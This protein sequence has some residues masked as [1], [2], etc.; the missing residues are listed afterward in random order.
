MK[1]TH[2]MEM[3]SIH[4]L[5]H[6]PGEEVDFRSLWGSAVEFSFIAGQDLGLTAYKAL[7]EREKHFYASYELCSTTR[8]SLIDKCLFVRKVMGEKI[9]PKL[10]PLMNSVDGFVGMNIDGK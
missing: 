1:P 9:T 3:F 6:N 4:A 2:F 8:H 7:S 10:A 5:M